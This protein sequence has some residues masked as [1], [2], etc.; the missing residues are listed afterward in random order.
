VP[1]YLV[2]HYVSREDQAA[3]EEQA[4]LARRAAE[5]LSR[6]GT[7]VH[8]LRSIFVPEDE[9]C[10][11]VFEAESVDG[12]R[13]AAAQARLPLERVSEAIET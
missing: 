2:E 13:A 8:Y 1:Q 5:Q 11:H 9:T 3:V 4:A 7:R 6:E 10:F 12:V